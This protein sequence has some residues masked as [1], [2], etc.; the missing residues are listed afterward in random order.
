MLNLHNYPELRFPENFIWGSA[1]SAH[2]IEGDD[3]HSINWR[4]QTEH[5]ERF[6]HHSGKA[7]NSY[8]LYK[9][10][11]ALLV[12]LGHQAYR[13]SIPWS[14]IE[15]AQ[16]QFCEEAVAHYVDL[17][18]RL[19]QA[20]IRTFVTLSH[21]SDPAWFWDKG[22]FGSRESLH[23]FERY[24]DFIVP[25]L[26]SLVDYWMTINEINIMERPGCDRFELRKNYMICHARAFQIIRQY[27]QKPVG[28]P[29][30]AASVVPQ[31]PHFEADRAHAAMEDW[32]L[33]G[34]FYHAL[35]TGE[36]VYPHTEAETFPEMKDSFDFWA[37]NYYTRHQVSARTRSGSGSLPTY[38]RLKLIDKEFYMSSFWPEGLSNE[39]KRLKDKPVFVTENGCCCTDDRWRMIKMIQDLSAVRDAMDDGV[40]IRGLL[41]WSLMDN[42]EWVSFIPRFGM[43]HVDF[44]TFK[45]TPKPSAQLFRKIIE[46]HGFNP[47]M[48][49]EF[50]PELPKFQLFK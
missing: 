49:D 12:K 16:G 18:E 8:A 9:E 42:Y 25:R 32:I 35:R 41:H 30:A 6:I 19:K 1:T 47:A 26:E 27:S 36:L 34:F 37:I 2:Q 14:R 43:V 39:L 48:L 5:P 45:R 50:L 23:F 29:H 7:C 13:F 24:V 11:V 44:E 33:N 20:N 38:A 40:E 15:P 17:L 22:G 46:N 31:D 4:D 21:G 10:D 28:A 3:I